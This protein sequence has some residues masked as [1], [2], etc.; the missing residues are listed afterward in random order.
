MDKTQTLKWVRKEDGVIAGVAQGVASAL[1]VEPWLVR[2]IFIFSTL[3]GG[4]G[5]LAYILMWISFPRAANLEADQQKMI[6][7]VCLEFHRRGD[8]ELGLARLLALM[9]FLMSF[10][11]AIV[12]YIVLYAVMKK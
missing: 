9:L 6:L 3:I 2:L 12:G 4:F 11:A 10:G 5:I 7:G 8:I 1:D